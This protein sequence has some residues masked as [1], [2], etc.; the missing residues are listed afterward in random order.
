MT[1]LFLTLLLLPSLLLGQSLNV[2]VYNDNLGVIRD[3]RKIDISKGQSKISITNV[4]ENIDPTSVHI[5]IDGTVLEQNYQYDLVSMNK[6]LQKYIDNEISLFKDNE[7][8]KGTLL[9]VGN[10]NIVLKNSNGGLIMLPKFEDYRVSV[11]E[12]PDGLI[13]RPTL[14]WDVMANKSGTQEVELSYQ[15]GGMKWHA[16]YVAVL[17]ENDTK[18][19]I[20]AWVSVENRSGAKYE[21]AKLKLVAGDVNRVYQNQYRDRDVMYAAKI[22]SYEDRQFEEKAFFEYH[23]YN[24]QREATISNNEIKQISLFD[25]KDV[26]VNKKYNLVINNYDGEKKISVVVEI[27]NSNKN[28]LGIPMPKGTVRVNKSDGNSIEFIGEDF[29]DHTPK[30]E[31]V[32][33]KIGDAFDIVANIQ[34]I[35]HKRISD[36]IS[37]DSYEILI[38]NKKDEDITV[39]VERYMGL[40]WEIL[41]ENF[42]HKKVNASK[43]EY[44]VPVKKNAESTLKIKIRTG[45]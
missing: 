37:E 5:K 30:D 31:T 17:N 20:N 22:A 32:K 40:N 19:D 35:D 42:K 21:N 25:A 33:L 8:I 4:A 16:E 38:K 39:N 3:I 41:N 13:T 12:L 6:I 1:K 7:F 26:A 2:T 18:A 45:I 14:V 9:S 28:N 23:I 29:I 43:V 27:D 15:T 11:E 24:L 36:R 34:H 10:N 44:N